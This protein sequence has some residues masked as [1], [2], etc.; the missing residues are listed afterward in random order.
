MKLEHVINFAQTRYGLHLPLPQKAK[1]HDWIEVRGFHDV[2]EY[3]Q[4][5]KVFF[6]FETTAGATPFY[7]YRIDHEEVN[8]DKEWHSPRLFIT[9]EDAIMQFPSLTISFDEAE[10]L[11]PLNKRA[12]RM[13][14]NFFVRKFACAGT[15]MAVFNYECRELDINL[16]DY[17]FLWQRCENFIPQWLRTHQS[18]HL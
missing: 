17:Y 10:F 7:G 15:A 4:A 16:G 9:M 8:C 18:P 6:L 11:P 5:P 2:S 14:S 1:D 3:T 13:P 12:A